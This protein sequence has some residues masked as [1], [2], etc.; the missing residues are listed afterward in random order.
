[1]RLNKIKSDGFTL[2]ELLVTMV[3]LTI[4]LGVGVPAFNSIFDSNRLRGAADALYF[5]LN[6]AKTE[7]IK[8]NQDI[9]LKITTNTAWCVGVNSADADCDCSDKGDCDIASVSSVD[10]PNLSLASSRPI[11]K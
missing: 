7:S 10:Y 8:I 6:L 4:L 11:S 1:M 5:S 3:I 9:F 2:Y